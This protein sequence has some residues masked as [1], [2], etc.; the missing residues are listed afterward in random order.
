MCARELVWGLPSF[1]ASCCLCCLVNESIFIV[2]EKRVLLSNKKV[3][4][5]QVPSRAGEHFCL[6]VSSLPHKVRVS[7]AFR[8]KK[9]FNSEGETG[10]ATVTV[11]SYSHQVS[12]EPTGRPPCKTG[13]D[14]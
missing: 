3:D 2:V 6:L 13:R 12:D 5:A 11:I 10:Q 7:F 9:S 4:V 1:C 8:V 14:I